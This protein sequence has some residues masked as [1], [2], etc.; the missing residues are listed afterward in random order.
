M[1]AIGLLKL[2]KLSHALPRNFNFLC[3][4]STIHIILLYAY[5]NKN[6]ININD[7]DDE[8]DDDD[9]DDDGGGGG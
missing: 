4:F 1:I 9:D 7:D 6:R 8:N 3:I 5:N 2:R